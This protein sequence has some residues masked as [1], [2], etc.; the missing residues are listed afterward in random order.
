LFVGMNTLTAIFMFGIGLCFGSFA[1]ATAW[2]I[3]KKRDFVKDTSECEQCGH[4]LGANDLVPLFSWLLLKGR[5]RY[6]KKATSKL[7]PLSELFGG[8][9]FAASYVYWP[10]ELTGTATILQYIVWLAACVLLF[11]LFFYDLQWYLLPNKVMYP[12]WGIGA[13][14]AVL[15]LVNDSH[16]SLLLLVGAVAIGAGLFYAIY[17][18]SSGA[19]IG[20]GDVRLGVA[21]GLLLGTPWLAGLALFLASLFGLVV[22]LPLLVKGKAGM[23]AKI[24]FGPLLILGLLVAKLWGQGIIDWYTASILLL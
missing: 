11:I 20:F 22:S 12:L 13:V 4:K 1:L 14:Y 5:C 10:Q 23:K 19:W 8:L 21:I 18:I 6:C 15:T 17:N 2:R 24:P 9:V 7:L 16:V 3:R